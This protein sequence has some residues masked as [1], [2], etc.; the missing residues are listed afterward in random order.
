[1]PRLSQ[2]ILICEGCK[3]QLFS[4]SAFLVQTKWLTT[5]PSLSKE[6]FQYGASGKSFLSM[7][8][9]ALW[10]SQIW[11]L[12][13]SAVCATN[14]ALSKETGK[15]ISVSHPSHTTSPVTEQQ[16]PWT[17]RLQ[18]W[19]E[20]PQW[21]PQWKSCS[22]NPGHPSTSHSDRG[23]AT[24]INKLVKASCC[25]PLGAAFMATVLVKCHVT[26]HQVLPSWLLPW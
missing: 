10:E 3:S 24:Q 19:A 20:T 8:F 23:T 12:S 22:G 17:W 26:C 6:H 5:M 1:M 11:L 13:V 14:C 2:A 7:C 9:G 15:F 21:R 25:L 16:S 4:T 18:A